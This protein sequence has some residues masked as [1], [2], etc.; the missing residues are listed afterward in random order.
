MTLVLGIILGTTVTLIAVIYGPTLIGH[1][2]TVPDDID[3][4]HQ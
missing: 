1:I 2:L 4:S 3:G